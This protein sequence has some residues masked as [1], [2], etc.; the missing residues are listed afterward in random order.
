ME[1]QKMKNH[2]I[3]NYEYETFLSELNSVGNS[4]KIKKGQKQFELNE[5]KSDK[6]WEPVIENLYYE[7]NWLITNRIYGDDEIIEYVEITIY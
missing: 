7:P 5:R 4:V 1:L 3:R 6:S 2:N